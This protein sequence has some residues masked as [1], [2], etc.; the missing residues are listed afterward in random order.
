MKKAWKKV[1]LYIKGNKVAFNR[2]NG[3]SENVLRKV[4]N[5]CGEKC[6]DLV[7]KNINPPFPFKSWSTS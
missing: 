7:S 3:I 1:N 6:E 5:D 4:L 2:K